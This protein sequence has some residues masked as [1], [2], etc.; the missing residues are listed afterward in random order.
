MLFGDDGPTE[1]ETTEKQHPA[2]TYSHS[3]T[4][5]RDFLSSNPPPDSLDPT[6]SYQPQPQFFDQRSHLRHQAPASTV[7]HYGGA[8][9]YNQDM[10]I[11][12]TFSHAT[13]ASQLSPMA[14]PPP[15]AYA[16]SPAVAQPWNSGDYPASVAGLP[17]PNAMT[18]HPNAGLRGRTAIP[19]VSS[20]PPNW[21]I[22]QFS[23]AGLPFCFSLCMRSTGLT[24]HARN[25]FI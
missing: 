5:Y 7:D 24:N 18:Q 9:P 3:M 25:G 19:S 16:Y 12:N 1:L 6:G 2:S 20:S 11:E 21:Q 14:M 10:P 22:E 8:L 4:M 23:F 15:Y 17:V 13:P